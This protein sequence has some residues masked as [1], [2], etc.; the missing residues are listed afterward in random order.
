MV[1]KHEN[2]E[3]EVPPIGDVPVFIA[4][5][6]NYIH[7]LAAC[8]EDEDQIVPICSLDI[9]FANYLRHTG[10]K[11]NQENLIIHP[12]D[13]KEQ[14]PLEDNLDAESTFKFTI[15]V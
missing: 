7:F 13:R 4:L 11:I 10:D 14:G 1:H 12:I 15:G 3:E 9:T 2:D 5:H 6:K 8:T